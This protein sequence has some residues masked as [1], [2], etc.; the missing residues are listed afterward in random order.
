MKKF[1]TVGALGLAAF[2]L[3]GAGPRLDTIE[4]AQTLLLQRGI[5]L[6]EISQGEEVK[7]GERIRTDAKTTAIVVYPDG[8]RVTI[9][10]NTDFEI[11]ASTGIQF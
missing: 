8:S 11:E 5:E 4:G 9:K 10:P 3:L 2:G 7:P 1:T 6:R